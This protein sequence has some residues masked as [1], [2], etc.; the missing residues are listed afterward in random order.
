MRAIARKNTPTAVP[1]TV[2]TGT[3]GLPSEWGWGIPVALLV[4]GGF[5]VDDSEV[6]GGSDEVEDETDDV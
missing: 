4:G 2:G 5:G 6:E 1:A 3:E